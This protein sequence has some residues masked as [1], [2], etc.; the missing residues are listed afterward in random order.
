MQNTTSS[1]QP[2]NLLTLPAQILSEI[3]IYLHPETSLCLGLTCRAT[4]AKHSELQPLPIPLLW[5]FKI[6]MLKKKTKEVLVAND[7]WRTVYPLWMLLAE[8]FGPSYGYDY[9]KA[10]FVRCV[11]DSTIRNRLMTLGSGLYENNA[12]VALER[13]RKHIKYE[14]TSAYRKEQVEN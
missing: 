7:D 13:Y 3:L 9:G 5:G 12:Q 11:A 14:K 4:Y 6:V 2:L 1:N 10:K 8:W